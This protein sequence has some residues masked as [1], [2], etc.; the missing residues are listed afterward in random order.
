MENGACDG[1]K[2]DIK[3]QVLESQIWNVQLLKHCDFCLKFLEKVESKEF[4]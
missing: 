3:S 2:K 4:C 1:P